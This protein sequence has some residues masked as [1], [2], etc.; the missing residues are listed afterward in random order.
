VSRPSAAPPAEKIGEHRYRI[1]QVTVDTAART[2]QLP[3]RVNMQKG[4]IEYLAVASEGKLHESALRVDAEPLHL[5][6]ALLLLGLEPG[7]RPRYQGDPTLPVPAAPP[8]GSSSSQSSWVEARVEWRQGGRERSARLEEWAWDIPARRPM[9]PVA[10]LFTGAS[11]PRPG[12][13]LTEQRSIVATY[14][15]PDAVLNNPLPTGGDD[16]VYKVNERVVPPVGTPVTLVLR[17]VSPKQHGGTETRRHGE[18]NE[19]STFVEGRGT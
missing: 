18:G 16:T 7:P 13:V 2:A 5:H 12:P 17:P 3:C 9:A 6:L 8:D 1:G 19:H 4:M 14:R 10:W 15:D 11:P